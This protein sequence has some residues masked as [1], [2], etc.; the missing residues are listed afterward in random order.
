MIL[1]VFF[2]L[3]EVCLLYIFVVN[4]IIFFYYGLYVVFLYFVFDKIMIKWYERERKIEREGE[5]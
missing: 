3:E 1:S 5:G 4:C 2:V